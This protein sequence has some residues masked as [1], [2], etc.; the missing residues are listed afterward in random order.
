MPHRNAPGTVFLFGTADPEST[1]FAVMLDRLFEMTRGRR[2]RVAYSLAAAGPDATLCRFAHRLAPDVF[3]GASVERFTVRGEPDAMP[4][5]K[6]QAIVARADLVFLSG[7]DPVLGA[8][9]LRDSGAAAWLCRARAGGVALAGGSAGAILLGAWWADWSRR[10]SLVRCT[11]IVADVVVDAHA[12]RAGWPE[13][14][15]LANLLRGRR[16]GLRF[17]G[18]PTGTGLIV[19]GD[20]RL[21]VVGHPVFFLRGA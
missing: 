14:H 6:A 4:A 13:L 7:G 3:R 19:E 12:E 1:A 15:G 21:E 20:D 10:P 2:P 5:K 18:I 8:R 17:L 11:A 16:R 9:I